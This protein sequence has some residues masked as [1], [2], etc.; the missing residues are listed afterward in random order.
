MTTESP[1]DGSGATSMSMSLERGQHGAILKS[2]GLSDA[3]K[4]A[5][6]TK[7]S[8]P[9]EEGM[10]GWLCVLGAGLTLFSSFGFLNA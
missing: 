8:L 7:T 3:E 10:K 9:P 1:E 4:A 5:S 2:E 6:S